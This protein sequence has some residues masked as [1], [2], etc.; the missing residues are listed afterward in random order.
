M[1]NNCVCSFK[2]ARIRG[3]SGWPEKGFTVVELLLVV[4]L[5]GV[6]AAAAYP[7]ISTTMEYYDTN[8]AVQLVLTNL[9]ESRQDAVDNRRAFRLRFNLPGEIVVRRQNSNFRWILDRRLPLPENVTFN[10]PSGIPRITIIPNSK[11]ID[12]GGKKTFRFMADGSAVNNN[13]QIISGIVYISHSSRPE[14]CS[15]VSVFGGTGLTRSWKYEEG[16]WN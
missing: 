13:G 12:F 10:R 5:A 6:V 2:V 15:A 4:A 3:G 9:R 1:N 16:K 7:V 11:D 14:E 8:S